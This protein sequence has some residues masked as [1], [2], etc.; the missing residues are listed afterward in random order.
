MKSAVIV[1]LVALIFAIN[2]TNGIKG[3]SFS[4]EFDLLENRHAIEK[5]IEDLIL[6]DEC[7]FILL[8][9]DLK[10]PVARSIVEM[11]CPYL[12]I[13]PTFQLIPNQV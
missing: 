3:L 9:V 7:K 1:L 5:V 4:E 10:D 13:Y 6:P 12:K 2:L 11:A 8:S